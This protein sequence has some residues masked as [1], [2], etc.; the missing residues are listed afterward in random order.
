MEERISA[1]VEKFPRKTSQRGII[2]VYKK[3]IKLCTNKCQK[4]TKQ[5]VH[6]SY[7]KAKNKTPVNVLGTGFSSL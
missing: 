2:K 6:I 3:Y 7:K 1:C 5:T 4:M